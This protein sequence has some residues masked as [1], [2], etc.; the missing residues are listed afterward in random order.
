MLTSFVR[1]LASLFLMAAVA[2]GQAIVTD[3]TTMSFA[4]PVGGSA[5]A[6]FLLVSSS[7]SPLIVT[8]TSVTYN[9]TGNWLSV[10]PTILTT[11]RNVVVSVNSGFLPQGVY[12][13]AVTVSAT[14]STNGAVAVN[15]TL[16][17]GSPP[18]TNPTN[19]TASP[20]VLSFVA[21]AGGLAPNAQLLNIASSPSGVAFAIA[22]STNDAFNWLQVPTQNSTAPTA[23]TVY[24]N[25]AGMPVGNYT[26][27]VTL[28]PS[29][30]G[31]LTIPVSLN[32]TSGTALVANVTSLQFYY[33]MGSF[34]PVQQFF[35]LSSGGVPLSLSIATSTNDGLA[36]LS[37]NNLFPTT[38]AN[39]TVSVATANLAAGVYTGKIHVSA[40]GAANQ[41]IDI[42]VTLTISGGPLLTVGSSPNTF[43]YQVGSTQPPAAQTVPLASTAGSL[44]YTVTT[45]TQDGSNWLVVSPVNGLTPQNLSIGVNPQN[46]LAGNY[47]GVVTVVA[48]GAANS[49]IHIPVNLAVGTSSSLV[50][51]TQSLSFNYQV[52]GMNN[53]L[54]QPL[55]VS[56]SGQAV[57]F[58]T[59]ATTSTCGSNWLQVFP[60]QATTTAFLTVAIQPLGFNLPQICTGTVVLTP[61][62]G[63]PI[64]V[65][66]ALTVSPNPL[67]NISPLS[68]LFSAPFDSEETTSQTI[69]LSVTDASS[70]TF[71]ASASTSTGGNAWLQ[72]TRNS[73]T[74][75]AVLT[76]SANPISL[77]VGTYSGSISI[78]SPALPTGQL[79]PVTFK[80]T[81]ASNAVVS[82]P[83]V[84]F[85]QVAGGPAPAAQTV[86]VSATGP[87]IAYSATTSTVD[88]GQWLSVAPVSGTT[89]GSITISANG[90]GLGAGVYSGSVTLMLPGAGNSPFQIPVQLTVTAAQT[91]VVNPTSLNFS[92]QTGATPP[93]SQPLNVTSTGA[94]TTVAATVGTGAAWLRVSPASGATPVPFAVSVVPG[95]M[96]VGSYDGTV[97]LNPGG[98]TPITVP[99]H[100]EITAAPPSSI[101]S[102]SNAASGVRGVISPG[103]IVTLTG[104][105]MGP[106]VGVGL[107]LQTDG[108]LAT[109]VAGTQVFFDE[110]AAPILYTSATQVNT[111]V[112][113]EVVGRST[114]QVS[115]SYQGIRTQG[116]TIQVGAAAPGIFTVTQTGRG[117]GA[118]LNQ[119][120]KVN[121][122]SIP[123][124]RGTI[125]QVFATG[126]GVTDPT[127]ATGSVTHTTHLPVAKVTAT[128]GGAPAEVVFAGAAPEA[129]AGL[130]QVNIRIPQ[131][132]ASGNVPLTITVGTASSQ[133]GVTVAIQ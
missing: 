92:Y 3:Q 90:N 59:S 107:Q 15:V 21:Q 32:L 80:V 10:S 35:T 50:V 25:T 132:A 49:P 106:A 16:T 1:V 79:I 119:D 131:G 5:Q 58:T 52:G 56:S 75:P 43:V 40:P 34:L 57:T 12:Y 93:A 85:T 123:A 129:V 6:Q 13:G 95:A 83:S 42:P 89:P 23:L 4:A 102:I 117:Q 122:Q 81:A 128:I 76:V 103:E 65:P 86:S 97:I 68:L 94:A 84:S 127:A 2:Q 88:L 62:A 70:V 63:S 74:T 11:P 44:T 111:I 17:V 105:S 54:S 115:V 71:T 69:T 124:A 101:V 104:D 55:F 26:G 82:P 46:L 66:V 53:L 51:G 45:S 91:V 67:F 31:T 48:S 14:G 114:V 78:T 130:L 112:P 24:V 41:V 113:Y 33:Q 37:V 19:L 110:F 72:V 120:N 38:P 29:T 36:W 64:Q 109:T 108:S 9:S 126:E 73:T 30:G 118:I 98:A 96:T 22:T 133:A 116:F 28:T 100:L 125:V 7:G 18:T 99:V 8:A 87:A 27:T 39:I 20:T 61:S 60:A 77:S 121:S 47:S